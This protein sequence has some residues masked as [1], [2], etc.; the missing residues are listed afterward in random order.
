MHYDYMQG[1]H[2]FKGDFIRKP[3]QIL[4]IFWH[5]CATTHTHTLT[6]TSVGFAG[7]ETV[8]VV[9]GVDVKCLLVTLH[10]VTVF[11]KLLLMGEMS[12]LQMK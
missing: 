11:N 9:V 8:I 1:C 10:F 6:A 2:H 5:V 3:K 12:L 4:L 7:E